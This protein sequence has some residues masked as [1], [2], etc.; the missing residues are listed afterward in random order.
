MSPRYLLPCKCGQSTPIE[1]GQAGQTIDCSCGARLDVPTMREIRRLA[2]A[3]E[4]QTEQRRR[5]STGWNPLQGGTFAIGILTLVIAIFVLAWSAFIRSRIDTTDPTSDIDKF[6]AAQIS[7]MPIDQ[8]WELWL[9]ARESGLGVQTVPP[10]V[11]AQRAHAQFTTYIY[12]AA[13]F[14]LVGVLAMAAALVLRP[15][16]TT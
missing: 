9:V 6:V 11:M 13:A 12:V 7:N 10:H 3:E 2:Q 14:V 16:S 8:T 4:G 5:G 1:V 15:R